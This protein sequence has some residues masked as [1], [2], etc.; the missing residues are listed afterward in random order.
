MNAEI[1]RMPG[2]TSVL[3]RNWHLLALR[4]VAA[5]LFGLIT[6]FDPGIGLA[7]NEVEPGPQLGDKLS[8]Q[9]IA[10]VPVGL[11]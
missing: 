10:E 11:K 6:L 4:G 7:G 3:V 8:R 2:S 9:E 5:L 1:E